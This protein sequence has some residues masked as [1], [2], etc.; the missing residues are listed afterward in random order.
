[1]QPLITRLFFDSRLRIC[2]AT[3]KPAINST[4]WPVPPPDIDLDHLCDKHTRPENG[5]GEW[6]FEDERYVEWRNSRESKLL[7]L[8]GGPG[9]GKTMLAKRVAA[10]FLKEVDRDHPPGGLKLVYHFVSPEPPTDETPTDGAKLSQ[11]RL[12]KIAGDILYSILQQDENLSAGY[13]VEFRNQ[14]NIFFTNLHSIWKVLEKAIQDCRTDPV[15]IL[16]D[17]VDG[18]KGGSCKELIGRILGLMKTRTVKIFLSSRDV[19]HV[20]NHL[21]RYTKINLDTSHFVKEDLETF[22]DRRLNALNEWDDNLKDRAR[23]A[24]LEKAEGTFLWASLAIENLSSHSSGPDFESFLKKPPLV[25]EGVYR[26]MLGPLSSE[27]EGEVLNM[28][29]SVALA[30][31]PLSFGELAHILAWMEERAKTGKQPSHNA[32]STKIRLRTEAEIRKYV[33]SSLGFLRATDTT[34]S[35]VHHTAIE[36][37]FNEKRQ[38]GLVVLSKSEVDLTVSWECFRYLHHAFSHPKKFAQGNICGHQN[39]PYSQSLKRDRQRAAPRETTWE[40][41]RKDPQGAATKWPCL[42]YAA[43]SWFIHARRTVENSK[44]QLC[45]DSTRNW[46]QHQ[47]F[48]TS[49]IIRKPW[50]EICGDP[51][52]EALAGE[53]TPLHIVVCLGLMPLVEKALSDSTKRV[54]SNQSPLHLAAKFMSETYRILITKSKPSLLTAPDEYGNTPLHEAAT[55]GHWPMVVELVKR[56]TTLGHRKRSDE[57]NKKNHRGNTPLHLALQFDH[58]DIVQFL[59]KNG[60]DRSIKNNDQMTAS[61]LGAKLERG[62]SLVILKQAAVE[63]VVDQTTDDFR[64]GI[65]EGIVEEIGAEDVVEEAADDTSDEFRRGRVG[66]SD[67]SI[68]E[69]E[70]TTYRSRVTKSI[71]PISIAIAVFAA[72]HI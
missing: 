29:R 71:L 49:D 47:F 28:I 59:S 69:S 41:A 53:Q 13:R 67:I 46:L 14:G 36:Y 32:A 19:P 3:F 51:R 31:R 20:S 72:I 52:M 55:H 66:T 4:N 8:C 18:L 44:D 64:R 60:A 43:E 22:V 48:E 15:Y 33:Q 16:I 24:L 23:E 26:K 61:E 56:F 50:I 6:I 30:L 58:P 63:E 12:A 54:N 37:L 1:M 21:S 10:E 25:L 70:T 65:V 17:G 45:H 11:P 38:D 42:R 57:I 2:A 40:V 27:G 62:G 34:V 5:T 9:T 39:K 35:I 68:R 7:W